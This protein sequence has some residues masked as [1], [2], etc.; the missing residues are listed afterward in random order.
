MQQLNELQQWFGRAIVRRELDYETLE[1]TIKGNPQLSAERR[2]H[3]YAEGYQLR[4][5]ECMRAEYA[6]LDALLGRTLFDQFARS[7]LTHHLSESYTLYN[8][9][10]D[11]PAFLQSTRP[12]TLQNDQIGMRMPE[13]LAQL[14]RYRAM[15]IRG[16]GS[17][18]N[19]TSFVDPGSL[20]FSP[21]LRFK[22]SDTT[23]V[24]ATD[25]DFSPVINA[26]D[27]GAP[28]AFPELSPHYLMIYRHQYR[29]QQTILQPWQ[30]LFIEHC[31]GEKS[32]QSLHTAITD[33]LCA[34]L[35]CDNAPDAGCPDTECSE[36]EFSETKKHHS[37]DILSEMIHWL[38]AMV[39]QGVLE[40]IR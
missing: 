38:P 17:E 35:A 7:Y 32:W 8:L 28:P 34:N 22:R 40:V 5:L 37:G 11:F 24:M 23:F 36:A 21:Q 6:C 20:L 15:S 31:D 4:L 39:R 1:N 19:Q 25:F 9:G 30:A 13:Q 18:M 14:E 10:Q 33:Q 29:I 26:V 12:Q 3:I 27:Q 2:L 16:E